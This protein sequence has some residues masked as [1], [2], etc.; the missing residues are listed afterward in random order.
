M[1]E[2]FRQNMEQSRRLGLS[3]S[4]RL[5]PFDPDEELVVADHRPEKRWNA[6]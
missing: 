3:G 6:T 5:F 4:E 1:P 2:L